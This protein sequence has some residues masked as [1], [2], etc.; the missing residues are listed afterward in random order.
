[1]ESA[2]AIVKVYGELSQQDV[3]PGPRT[4]WTI[5]AFRATL[6]KAGH[7]EFLGCAGV[8]FWLDLSKWAMPN[9]AVN[10]WRSRASPRRTST[11]PRRKAAASSGP[12][13]SGWR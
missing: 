9:Q 4:P 2:R 6:G 1:M 7:G 11:P 12:A 10:P 8:L 13:R 5:E 3:G